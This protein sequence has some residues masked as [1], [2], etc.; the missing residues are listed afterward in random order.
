MDARASEPTWLSHLYNAFT[1]QGSLLSAK[2]DRLDPARR[3]WARCPN[4]MAFLAF[5]QTQWRHRLA[6]GNGS[7]LAWMENRLLRQ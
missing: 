4:W 1:S 5:F 2:P 6:K 7:V 3:C